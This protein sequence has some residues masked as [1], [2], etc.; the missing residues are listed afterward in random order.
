MSSKKAITLKDIAE[1]LNLSKVSVSKA[2]RDHPDIGL[3]TKQLVRE[4]AIRLGYV[5]NFIARN[6]SSRES[7]TIGLIVPKIAHHFFAS[8]IESIY[9]TAFDNN[10]ER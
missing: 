10:Y 7:K 4:T 5:P 6:L 1:E 8:A 3:E 2:L 9:Q